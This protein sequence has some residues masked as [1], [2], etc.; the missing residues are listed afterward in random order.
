M[1]TINKITEGNAFAL[2]I[3]QAVWRTLG[4][5]IQPLQASELVD[6][7]LYVGSGSSKST[8]TEYNVTA[9]G[10]SISAV[11]PAT[12]KRGVYRTWLTALYQGREVASACECAFEIVAFD[13]HGIYAP[14]RIDGQPCVYLQGISMS[15]AELEAQKTYYR[16]LIKQKEDEIA[17]L[18]KERE[19][20]TNVAMQLDGVDESLDGISETLDGVAKEDT[21]LEIK[22]ALDLVK[23]E[24]SVEDKLNIRNAIELKGGQSVYKNPENPALLELAKNVGTIPQK[25]MT[26]EPEGVRYDDPIEWSAFNADVAYAVSTAKA[27]QNRIDAEDGIPSVSN[28]ENRYKGFVLFR[29]YPRYFS[30]D[31]NYNTYKFE[32]LKKVCDA[33]MIQYANYTELIEFEP[34]E[35]SRMYYFDLNNLA[36]SDYVFMYM[37]FYKDD[38]TL[39]FDKN[40]NS[41]DV[42]VGGHPILISMTNGY[43]MNNCLV[44]LNYSNTDFSITKANVQYAYLRTEGAI[45]ISAMFLYVDANCKKLTSNRNRMLQNNRAQEIYI[46]GV[47]KLEDFNIGSENKLNRV[48]FSAIEEIK[49]STIGPGC[50][51]VGFSNLKKIE[52]PF[53]SDLK[54]NGNIGI[55]LS[56]LEIVISTKEANSRLFSNLSQEEITLPKL[57]S[58]GNTDIGGSVSLFDSCNH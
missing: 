7:H 45:N 29:I 13:E 41:G 32:L 33:Y 17:L 38:Y 9:D 35:N 56:N 28:P 46:Q 3:R 36:E 42:V 24:I 20:L 40:F 23:A 22:K 2:N 43:S 14:E 11:M 30:F 21:Q 27:F 31:N 34:G 19:K 57:K 6:V 37:L 49:T 54:F 5:V 52:C 58:V 26:L 44:Q 47:T 18:A 25:F 51:V 55:D 8:A 15:D 16:A 12:L 39:S 4:G 48:D 1:N 10:D 50:A 53:Y